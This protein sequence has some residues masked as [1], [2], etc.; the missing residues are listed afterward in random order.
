MHITINCIILNVKFWRQKYMQ[1]I[2]TYHKT[3]ISSLTAFLHNWVEYILGLNETRVKKN[4]GLN[5]SE[6]NAQRESKV[7]NQASFQQ[8]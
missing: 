3:Y 5:V 7:K 6:R 1:Y 2:K 4:P 8:M